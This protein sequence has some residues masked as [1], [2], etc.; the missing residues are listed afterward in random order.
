MELLALLACEL[1]RPVS[2]QRA[3]SL[4][5]DTG[6]E[7]CRES[8]SKA[9][10]ALRTFS[11]EH[12]DFLPLQSKSGEL[13]LN[14]TDAWC[15]LQEFQRLSREDDLD[16]KRRAAALYTGELF[17]ADCFDWSVD[18]AGLYEIAY[19]ELCREL[20]EDYRQQGMERLAES[21]EK[22]LR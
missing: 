12:G 17:L 13:R 5:W 1:G 7:Q 22:I 3:A 10:Q 19:L 8:L 16:Q 2:K 6:P 20:A 15:D 18:Y 4:L 9:C 21:Y 11:A 14:L